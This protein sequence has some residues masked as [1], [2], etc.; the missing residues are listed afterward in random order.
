MFGKLAAAIR[1][2]FFLG[3]SVGTSAIFLAFGPTLA[4]NLSVAV[5]AGAAEPL[6][7]SVRCGKHDAG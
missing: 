7:E 5:K 1:E 2:E 3:I 4:N 6:P